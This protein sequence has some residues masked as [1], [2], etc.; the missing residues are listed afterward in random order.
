MVPPTCSNQMLYL[1]AAFVGLSSP[2]G[3]DLPVMQ[4]STVTLVR[5][6]VYRAKGDDRSH[7]NLA[8]CIRFRSTLL[9]AAGHSAKSA[10]CG[11]HLGYCVYLARTFPEGGKH[12]GSHLVVPRPNQQREPPDNCLPY[13]CLHQRGPPAPMPSPPGC[14][15]QIDPLHGPDSEACSSARSD[16]CGVFSSSATSF[17][18]RDFI[19]FSVLSICEPL[20]RELSAENESARSQHNLL[21]PVPLRP[22]DPPPGKLSAGISPRQACKSYEPLLAS[23]HPCHSPQSHPGPNLPGVLR[24]LRRTAFAGFFARPNIVFGKGPRVI[25]H[26]ARWAFKVIVVPP[27]P[28]LAATRVGEAS[29]PG[30]QGDIRSYFPTA[31]QAEHV[32]CQASDQDSHVSP[33]DVPSED[34][35]TMAVINPTSV[36]NKSHL[37]AGLRANLI[38]ASETS[39]VARV[40][41]LTAVKLRGLGLSSVWGDPV[42]AHTSSKTGLDTLRGF[43]AGVAIFGNLPLSQPT[44]AIPSEVSQT[45]RIVEAMTR[46]GHMQVRLVCVYGFPASYRDARERNQELFT[47]VLARVSQSRLPTVIAGDL[48]C[49]V[50]LLPIWEN[51]RHL[52]YQ[53]VFEMYE[54]RMRQ[55]LPATCKGSS[56]HD[57]FLLPPCVQQMFRGA[58]VLV[59]DKIFD[60]HEPLVVTLAP[61]AVDPPLTWRQP[62]SWAAFNP[63]MDAVLHY[64]A[65]LRRPLQALLETAATPED[66]SAAFQLWSSTVEDSV[67]HALRE[68]HQRDPIANPVA[69][70]PRAARGRCSNLVR[71]PRQSVAV[72][73]KGRHGDYDPSVEAASIKARQQVRQVRRIQSL[74]RRRQWLEGQSAPTPDSLASQLHNEWRAILSSKAFGPRFDY[75]LIQNACFPWVWRANPPADWLNEVYQYAKF[76]CEASLRHE[77]NL[78]QKRFAYLVQWD[79]GHGSSRQ[80][81]QSLR[82]KSRPTISSLPTK[83]VRQATL[84]QTESPS[85][86]LYETHH[87]EFLRAPAPILVQGETAMLTAILPGNDDE[88]VPNLVRISFSTATLPARCEFCQHSQAMTSLE[89]QREFYEFWARIW[90]RDTKMAEKSLACWPDFQQM[91]PPAP[92]QT[93][94]ELDLQL[95]DVKVWEA[96]V[97]KLSPHKATGYDGWSNAELRQLQGVILQDLASLFKMCSRTG[98]PA[99]L[100]QARVSTLAKKDD[101]ASMADGRPITVFAC[102]YRLWASLVAKQILSSW[103]TW[104]PEAVAGCVP[105]RSVQDISYFLQAE[106]EAALCSGEPKGGFS[107]DIIKAFNNVPRA[108]V[109]ALLQ[110]LGVPQ[111]V[112]CLWQDFLGKAQRCAEFLGGLGSP[113]GATTGVPEGDPMSVVAM[114]SLCWLASQVAVPAHS[115]LRTYVD[116]FSWLSSNVEGLAAC[117]SKAQSFCHALRLPIDWT[118]SYSWGTTHGIR[119]WLDVS[120]PTLL[121]QGIKLKRVEQAKDLGTCFR[122]SKSCSLSKGEPRLQEGL[123]R[124]DE[125]AK[126]PRPPSNKA[127]LIQAGIWPQCFYAQEG[128]ALSEKQVATFRSKAAK[129]LSAAGHSQSAFLTLACSYRTVQDP[130]VFLLVQSVMALRRAFQV[131]PRTAAKVLA[132]VWEAHSQAAKVLGPATALACLLRRNGWEVSPTGRCSGPGCVE[133]CLHSCSRKQVTDSVLVAWS[134]E[135]HRQV[136]HRNGLAS[137]GAIDCRATQWAVKS[138]PPAF[139]SVA[140]NCISGGHMSGAA[141]SLWDPL[142]DETCKYCGAKDTKWH[143]CFDCPIFQEVRHTFR[144]MLAWVQERAPHWVHAAVAVEHPDMH[145]LRML[146][147]NRTF[148]K[149]PDPL[150]EPYKNQWTFFTD[151]SCNVPR[152]PEARHAACCRN[153]C[154]S[155]GPGYWPLRILL[156]ARCRATC[157]PYGGSRPL[158]GSAKYRKG[159]GVRPFAGSR[160][161]KEVPCSCLRGVV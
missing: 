50:Q 84:W 109:I 62:R 35:I 141:R 23:P 85:V 143:R 6:G 5:L 34:C 77:A 112:A 98:F 155:A 60:A 32:H 51:L 87:L 15:M 18:F 132:R 151:G 100:A 94:L 54:H 7:D 22:S 148:V 12:V 79:I 24:T 95:D 133:F 67:H 2:R 104:L 83:E 76:Q 108:P 41:H 114:V 152:C 97:R 75:W 125:L 157:V 139:H 149:A 55:A 92:E 102:T 17:A 19:A 21:S 126:Q 72:A 122:F 13:P 135:L 110:H 40:Q 16:L 10:P 120:A 9:H 156:P 44:T 78:R 93:K 117:L 28:P 142:V 27:L 129:A 63:N 131:Q 91:L 80:G 88:D 37:I 96:A 138:L 81:F 147:H 70:L 158:P 105:H 48:N 31:T 150:C 121:P 123:R 65:E 128:R 4:V 130:E 68:E 144:P 57:T 61:A 29:H 59:D 36:H 119:R 82:P 113:F 42:P 58:K 140:L 33:I 127:Y 47:H 25:F 107:L 20:R 145:V 146:F 86:G 111:S 106:I 154:S 8:S 89:L 99:H 159:R 45:L 160:H 11:P 137:L 64:Y 103:S 14:P 39:A 124:L 53:E 3:M 118:K 116:N 56:R 74:M 161:C 73:K 90:W 30:P 115:D 101:P 26:F 69:G 38:F 134:F 66:A 46:F 71:K 1:S 153:R 136:N 43:A 52:G 49:R